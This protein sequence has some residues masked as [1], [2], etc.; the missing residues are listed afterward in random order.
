MLTLLALVLAIGLV[1]DDAIVVLENIYAKVEAGQRP[2]EAAVAGTREIF[3]AVIATTVALVAVLLPL[4]FL[5][6]LTGRLFREFG[7]TLAGAVAISALVALTLT[8]MLSSRLLKR[9]DNP[10]HLYR[11]T[12]PF[13]QR[14]IAGYRDSLTAL[15]RIGAGWCCRWS[16]AAAP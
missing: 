14:M 8:P 13:F 3:F 15:P 10:S 11:W 6:G 5:G 7:A 1:V 16:S 4:L 2:L 12:E 9:H